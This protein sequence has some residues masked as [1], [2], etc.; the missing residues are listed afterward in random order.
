MTCSRLA[1]GAVAAAALLAAACG[2]APTGRYRIATDPASRYDFEFIRDRET[3]Q[4]VQREFEIRVDLER[5]LPPLRV[6][7]EIGNTFSVQLFKP[8]SASSGG[9]FSAIPVEENGFRMWRGADVVGP[10]DLRGRVAYGVSVAWLDPGRSTQHDPMEM[11]ELPPL[12]VT[13]PNE[14]SAWTTAGYQRAGAMGWWEEANGAPQVPA[15]APEHPFEFR[16]RLVFAE[17]PGRIP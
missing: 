16:W 7:A 12:G 9:I 13:V 17:I 1:R 14:W 3:G 11:F 10:N 8:G 4:W 5:R 6:A 2:G 15:Q